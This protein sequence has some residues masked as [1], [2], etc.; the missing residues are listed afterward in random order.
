MQGI[1]MTMKV[2]TFLPICLLLSIHSYA[3]VRRAGWST[4]GGDPQRTGWERG[5]NDLTKEN[6][7]DLKVEWSIKLD[8]AA[9]ELNSLTIP[10]VRG[11]LITQRGFKEVVVVAGASD[12]IFVIDSDSGK[13]FWEKTMTAATP[14]GSRGSHWLC[15]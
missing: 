10:L 8:N 9:K 15:P 11:P 1:R 12:K 4:Y 7:K 2:T 5:E 3:Q 13:V 14:A 6:V